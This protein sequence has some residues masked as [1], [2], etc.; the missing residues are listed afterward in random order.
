[1]PKKEIIDKYIELY[2]QGFS[3]KEML[4]N[5]QDEGIKTRAEIKIVGENLLKYERIGER[6]TSVKEHKEKLRFEKEEPI[7]QKTKTIKKQIIQ[8][9]THD[10]KKEKEI[11]KQ[12][13]Q[14]PT[15]DDK[16]EKETKKQ[17]KQETTEKEKQKKIE[18]E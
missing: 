4:D 1:M 10:E 18:K 2:N 13:E 11:K 16:K 14:K 8:K 3:E 9:P 7:E 12:S 17:N 6:E 15:H 5:L